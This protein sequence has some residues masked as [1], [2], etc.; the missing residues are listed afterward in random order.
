VRLKLARSQI[1]T[2]RQHHI[3]KICRVGQNHIYIYIYTA[4]VRYVW[5]GDHQIY[6]HMRCI[7]TILANPKT[8]KLANWS[9]KEPKTIFHFGPGAPLCHF[10]LFFCIPVPSQRP[11]APP[12]VFGLNCSPVAEVLPRTHDS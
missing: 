2:Q 12:C 11:A 1:Y 8:L 3:H 10:S 4:Y 5:Q 7:Y 6:S 9:A